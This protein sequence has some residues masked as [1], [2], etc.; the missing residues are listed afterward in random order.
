MFSHSYV[1]T[2][3]LNAIW[4]YCAVGAEVGLNVVGHKVGA[5]VGG[6]GREVGDKVGSVGLDE[7]G[8]MVG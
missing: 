1:Q 8:A 3:V 5:E 2:L 7:V 4:T 6:V